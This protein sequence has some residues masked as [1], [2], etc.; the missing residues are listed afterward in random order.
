VEDLRDEGL[1]GGVEQ[2][3]IH[4]GEEREQCLVWPAR[5]QGQGTLGG[6]SQWV[7]VNA[8]RCD[9]VKGVVVGRRVAV[10]DAQVDLLTGMLHGQQDSGQCRASQDGKRGRLLDV[11]VD[12][13]RNLNVER[14]A[15]DAN[16]MHE[17][18]P[19]S[20]LSHVR[21]M[22]HALPPGG[23]HWTACRW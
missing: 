4:P 16:M 19:F 11:G 2:M 23:A 9:A 22:V 15:V 14:C 17:C 7:V 6:V 12:G 8:C 20:S 1:E 5:F 13:K 3:A 21:R 10:P 18:S